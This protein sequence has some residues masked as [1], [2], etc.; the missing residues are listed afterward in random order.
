M[1]DSTTTAP[2]VLAPG[3]AAKQY[4]RDLYRYKELYA[5]LAWRDISV[6]YKQ[7]AFGVAWAVLRPI[8]TIA[9]F[10]V[11]FGRVA[12][13]PSEG[14]APYALLVFAGMLAWNLCS[15]SLSDAA[16]SLVGNASL[17]SKVYF[18]RMIVPISTVVVSL[19]DFLL[20]L[21]VLFAVMVWFRFWPGWELLLLPAFVLLAMLVSIGPG[22]WVASLNVRYRDFRHVIPFLLQVGIYLSPVGFSSSV[23]PD[24]W[25]L[26]YSLNPMVGV[27]DGFRW[28]ILRG[29]GDLYLPS[30]LMS[31]VIGALWLWI[32]VR[33]FR[34]TETQFADVI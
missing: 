24:R 13:L 3:L 34:R 6:R 21:L 16:N 25:R 20:G 9:V 32:G 33:T 26:L 19:V 27:I 2:L 31:V 10:T 30:I 14:D 15:T 17:I 1:R 18:P 7:T 29:T 5:M 22:L 12:G 8:L 4:W 11:V 23:V 28:C